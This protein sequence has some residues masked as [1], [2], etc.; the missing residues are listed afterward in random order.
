MI[1]I[2]CGRK[3]L[4]QE[5]KSDLKRYE[6]EKQMPYITSIERMGIEQGREEKKE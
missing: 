5:F 4:K 2:H 3:S 1:M 6:Q